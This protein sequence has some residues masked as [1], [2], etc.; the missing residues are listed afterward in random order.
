MELDDVLEVGEDD[1]DGEARLIPGVAGHFIQC[2]AE[3]ASALARRCGLT[4]AR[5]H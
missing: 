5:T 3:P 1:M 2:P 4:G